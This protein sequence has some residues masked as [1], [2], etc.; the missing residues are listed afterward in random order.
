MKTKVENLEGFNKKLTIE[1]DA[2]EVD[3]RINK[4][5]KDFA[6]RYNFPGFRK[7][8]APR[9]I[10][11]STLGAQAVIA[12]VT[13]DIL[14][15]V[16]PLA[17]DENNL[18]PISQVQ[19]EESEDLVEQGKPFSYC[20]TVETRPEFELTDYKPI[21]VLLP[22]NEATDDEVQAQIDEMLNYYYDFEDAS[23][24]TKIKEDSFIEMALKAIDEKGEELESMSS[25]SRVYEV[26]MGLF[27][28]EFD[29]A[30]IGKKKG[31]KVSVTIGPD[32]PSMLTQNVNPEAGD[33]TFEVEVKQVKKRIVP[34]LTDEW[35][36]EKA[37]FESIADLRERMAEQIKMQKES[38]APRLRE[39]EALFEL[40]GR[41]KGEAPEVML[42]AQESEL[43]Q[44]FFTQLQQSGMSFDMFLA[45]NGMTPET[46]MDDLKRQA[47]DMV[48]Q[49]LALDAWA[50]H[51]KF[52]VTQEEISAQFANSGAEDPAALEKEWRAA[53]RMAALRQGMLRGKAIDDILEKLDVKELKEGEKLKSV[54]AREAAQEAAQKET[55]K[56]AKKAEKEAEKDEKKT[57]SG[58]KKATKKAAPK[59]KADNDKKED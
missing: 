22:S 38:L 49:D 55:E 47:A 45:Q 1:L 25:E 19:F 20:I 28:E 26:G 9:A 17:M 33:I 30:L 18:V 10:V 57:A 36:K 48:A 3:D 13:D 29:K 40:Q 7:G 46:F 6:Y 51:G 24:A 4:Q 56:K 52:E 35:V 16:T 50:R 5:Y 14:S 53:G 27:P 44:S 11:D 15:K 34:E 23:A 43:L 32:S 58:N 31:D 8:K 2:S 41:L 39:N 42:E 54:V 12:T 59:K 21:S 37:G